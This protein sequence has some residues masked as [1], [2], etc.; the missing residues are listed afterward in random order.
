MPLR[1]LLLTTLLSLPLLGIAQ[2]PACQQVS[3]ATDQVKRDLLRQFITDCYQT[4]YFFEDK[5]LV[6][7]ITYQDNKG[8]TAWY[9]SAIIDDRYRD[10]PPQTYSLLGN[11]IILV[12][13]GDSLGN[14]L[15]APTAAV[16][17]LMHCL[18]LVIG[19]AVYQ[20]PAIKERFVEET[21]GQK[22]TKYRVRTNSG[23]N[24]HHERRVIFN[25]DGT[26]KIYMPA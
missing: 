22:T 8:R 19:P 17:P 5:G 1:K 21:V 10:N 6:E 18:E 4:H 16:A 25:A 26:Y 15:R 2:V 7:L 13:Q 24:V 11:D 9:L 3:I 20:R 14:K 12:Y 23:G